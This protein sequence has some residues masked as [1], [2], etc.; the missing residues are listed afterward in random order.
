M[1]VWHVFCENENGF[2]GKTIFL[3][4][5]N[6]FLADYCFNKRMNNCCIYSQARFAPSNNSLPDNTCSLDTSASDTLWC[7]SQVSRGTHRQQPNCKNDCFNITVTAV[8]W[9]ILPIVTETRHK[10][11]EPSKFQSH[12]Q[13][14]HYNRE[15]MKKQKNRRKVAKASLLFIYMIVNCVHMPQSTDTFIEPSVFFLVYTFK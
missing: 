5:C 11:T 8:L 12:T 1:L 3:V 10:E 15:I 7:Q 6:D 9:A 2:H 14:L 4:F 13:S